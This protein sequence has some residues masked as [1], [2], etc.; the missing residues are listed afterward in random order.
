MNVI[1]F[2]YLVV[3]VIVTI[4]YCLQVCKFDQL[5]AL[6]QEL[7]LFFEWLLSLDIEAQYLFYFYVQ[8]KR[9]HKFEVVNITAF[10]DMSECILQ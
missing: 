5:L 6:C 8:V 7:A 4:K 3:P 2:H 10:T 9:N 1:T